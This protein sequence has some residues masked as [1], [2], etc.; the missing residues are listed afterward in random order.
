MRAPSTSASWRRLGTRRPARVHREV[1]RV[2]LEDH[3]WN[4]NPR[5]LT[6]RYQN[7]SVIGFDSATNTYTKTGKQELAK[8]TQAWERYVALTKNPTNNLAIVAANRGAERV[9]LIELDLRRPRLARY[10][11]WAVPGKP[12]GVSSEPTR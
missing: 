7:A 9:C 4:P 5:P 1:L 11:A 10:I 8:A 2:V 6:S 3:L 12:A